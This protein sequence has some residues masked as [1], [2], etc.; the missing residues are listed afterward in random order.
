MHAERAEYESSD[1]P[2]QLDDA[3]SGQRM[4][5]QPRVGHSIMDCL[6]PATPP[7]PKNARVIRIFDYEEKHEVRPREESAKPARE[8]SRS[9]EAAKA[10]RNQSLLAAAGLV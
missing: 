1:T 3:A 10:A 5:P 7:Q 9:R 8:E 2:G 4:I 6:M